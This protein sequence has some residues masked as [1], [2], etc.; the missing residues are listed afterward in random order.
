MFTNFVYTLIE[1]NIPV[2]MQYVI[3]FY[4]G[5]EKGIA[6]DIDDLFIFARLCF[7]K[8]VEHM[9]A[10]QRAF[11][12]YFFNIHLPEV[13]E[14][15]L[16]LLKTKEFKLWLQEAIK[17]GKIPKNYWNLTAKELMQKFW[18][19]VRE[20]MEAHNGGNRWIGTG[21]SSPFGHSAGE[22]KPGIRVYGSGGN[23]SAFKVI[24][25]RNYIDYAEKETITA[26]N[27]RQALAVLKHLKPSG[28]YT[29]LNIDET[30]RQTSRNGGEIELI[31]EREKIDKLEIILLIDNGGS[32]M[33]PYV[34]LTK[35]LFSKLTGH[36]K[37]ITTYYFHNTI[38]NE[39]Y[40]DS[41]RYK[42]Y[43]LKRLLE[44]PAET[45]IIIIGDASMAPGELT[46]SYGSIIF[47]AEDALPSTEYLKQIKDRFKHSV[48]LNPIP[49]QHWATE[50]GAW[51][52]QKI[53]SIFRMEDFTLQ[54][55]KN[56]VEFLNKKY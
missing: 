3:D 47:D 21:G 19:T 14:G 36:F 39:V 38:Y 30:I 27:I 53:K 32:S 49:K 6:E 44:N 12:F 2:S 11:A 20:Q 10:F 26:E 34:D 16:D 54:G 29:E 28:A 17:T 48:W 15:D 13:I 51:T 35:L 18:E 31:F 52:I 33:V 46:S 40:T 4:N 23:R 7:V 42:S 41:R 56:A 8:K 25:D 55:I 22:A 9:D 50:Y 43:P 37:R 5:L 1:Y 45:R 24:G